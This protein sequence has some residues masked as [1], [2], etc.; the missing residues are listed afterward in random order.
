M[1]IKHI[2][3]LL[4]VLVISCLLSVTAKS[5][6][7]LDPKKAIILAGVVAPESMD[8]LDIEVLARSAR[9]DKEIQLVIDSP[10]GEVGS[11]FAFV[12]ALE[13]VKANGT[14]VTCFVPRLA[15]SMG[16]QIFMHCSKRYV[17][18]G[19]N[20]MWHRLR[21]DFFS[22]TLT[23]ADLFPLAEGLAQGDQYIL[24]ELVAVMGE[25]LST[26]EIIEYRDKETLHSGHDLAELLPSSVEC[27]KHIV[28]LLES[29]TNYDI[30]RTKPISKMKLRLN[31]RKTPLYISPVDYK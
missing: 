11:G 12:D 1:N 26:K 13:A 23:S 30:P 17:L 28:G 5:E 4:I 25:D 20:L 10:G 8:G 18:P 6:I 15:A 3:L 19:A 31:G 24:D 7:K 27:K 21:L 16:Y 22:E 9:G 2:I 29:L 14:T